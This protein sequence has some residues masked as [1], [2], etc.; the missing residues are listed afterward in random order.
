MTLQSLSPGRS[1]GE[2]SFGADALW[3]R[4]PAVPS[5][6]G[7]GGQHGES[8]G[9]LQKRGRPAVGRGIGLPAL[10]AR[11]LSPTNAV[12]SAPDVSVGETMR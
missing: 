5:R 3:S 12:E 8:G 9:R 7:A 10:L 2:S 6:P 1:P 11:S 4:L